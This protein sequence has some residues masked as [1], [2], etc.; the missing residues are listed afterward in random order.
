MYYDTSLGRNTS[1]SKEI[2][3]NASH[4]KY[5]SEIYDI[6]WNNYRY[7]GSMGYY[8]LGNV[9]FK[10]EDG[11]L[12]KLNQQTWDSWDSYYDQN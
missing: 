7:Y 5:D 9:V 2:V 6:A 4:P 8:M 11:A 3:N 12:T 1:L 10:T